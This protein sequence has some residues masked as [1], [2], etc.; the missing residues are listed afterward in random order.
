M[1]ITLVLLSVFVIALIAY[2]V[3]LTYAFNFLNK[4][5]DVLTNTLNDRLK[6]IDERQDKNDER[7]ATIVKWCDVLRENQDTLQ[8][9]I[10]KL[11]YGVKKTQRAVEKSE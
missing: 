8:D 9:D 1:I 7:V 6:V 5:F 3:T 10:Q 4:K 2:A 11:H